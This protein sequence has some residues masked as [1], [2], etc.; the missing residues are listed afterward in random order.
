MLGLTEEKLRSAHLP[1]T[2]A[3]KTSD[4]DSIRGRVDRILALN[5][6]HDSAITRS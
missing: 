3:V 4:L 6:L 5:V 1:N 2:T